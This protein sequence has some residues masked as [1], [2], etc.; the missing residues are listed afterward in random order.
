MILYWGRTAALTGMVLLGALA[1]ERVTAPVPNMAQSTPLD[2]VQA[3]GNQAAN[4]N[5]VASQTPSPQ[6]PAAPP[7]TPAQPPAPSAGEGDQESPNELNVTVGK[8]LIVSTAQPI[9]RISVGYGD[10]AEAPA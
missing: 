8:S 1:A 4:P 9:E 5:P 7:K 6:A 3:P 10:V 2:A